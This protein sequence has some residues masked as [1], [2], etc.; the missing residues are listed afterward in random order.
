VLD[1]EGPEREAA[2][3]RLRDEQIA[4]ITTVR[5]DGQP[6]SSP[7]WFWWDGERFLVYSEPTSGKVANLA[8]SDRVSLH[9]EGDGRGG[10]IL[11][12][13][14]TAT[15]GPAGEAPAAYLEK[16]AQGIEALGLTPESMVQQYSTAIR[17]TPTRARAW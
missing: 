13:E 2:E 4:W 14:G 16:Y 3:A 9:L 11:T 8:T 6:Q 1:L 17:I 7:V 12:L 15:T 5:A 10:R